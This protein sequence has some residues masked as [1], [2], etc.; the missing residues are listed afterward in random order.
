MLGCREL[1]PDHFDKNKK[2]LILLFFLDTICIN[3]VSLTLESCMYHPKSPVRVTGG[4][5]IVC[6]LPF[7]P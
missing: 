1:N 2:L 5:P 7:T 4:L 6:Y 3:C